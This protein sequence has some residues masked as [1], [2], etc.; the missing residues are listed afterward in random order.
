MSAALY[1]AAGL[2]FRYAW[3]GSGKSSARDHEVVAQ[4]A[5]SKRHGY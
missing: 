2:I 5:R 4:M 3:V 1:L